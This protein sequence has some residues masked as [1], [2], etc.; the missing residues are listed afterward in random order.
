MIEIF[1][2]HL[3]E[4]VGVTVIP[5]LG[6]VMEKDENDEPRVC[7]LDVTSAKHLLH[8]SKL[9]SGKRNVFTW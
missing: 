8:L 5:L 9:A 7:A 1:S 6:F 3:A 4:G 2:S